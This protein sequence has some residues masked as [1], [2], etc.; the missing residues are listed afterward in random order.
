MIIPTLEVNQS[1]HLQVVGVNITTDLE[2]VIGIEERS[3][4]IELKFDLTLEWFEHRV[5]YHNL[6]INNA[7]N[8]LSKWELQSLWIPLIIF[9]VNEVEFYFLEN[10]MIL[11]PKLKCL[12]QNTDLNEKVTIEGVENTVFITREGNFTRS[13][14]ESVDEV[15]IFEGSDNRITMMQTYSKQFHCTYLLHSFPFDSQV[16][17]KKNVERNSSCSKHEKG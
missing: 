17:Q 13:G 15:E 5:K 8:I 9:K 11:I 1:K 14:L 3:H 10:E 12:L 7:L 6:K 16:G 4:V 2:A